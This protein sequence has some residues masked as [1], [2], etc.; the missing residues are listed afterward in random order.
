M[1]VELKIKGFSCLF[2]FFFI[3]LQAKLCK[4]AIL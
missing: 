2:A 4:Y 1:T 3:T